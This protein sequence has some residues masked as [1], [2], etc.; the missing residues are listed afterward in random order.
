M[1]WYFLIALWGPSSGRGARNAA[2]GQD[3]SNSATGTLVLLEQTHGENRSKWVML[4]WGRSLVTEHLNKMGGKGQG[5][6][7]RLRYDQRCVC[8]WW[9]DGQGSWKEIL[10]TSVVRDEAGE[11]AQA[12]IEA[13]AENLGLFVI[14]GQPFSVKSTYGLLAGGCANGISWSVF[15]N[16]EA[17]CICGYTSHKNS[18]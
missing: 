5:R 1:Q 10:R 6:H 17:Q 16:Q 12:A 11:V 2:V 13:D 9:G 4:V 3:N 7:F 14:E 15:S 8:V 18:P